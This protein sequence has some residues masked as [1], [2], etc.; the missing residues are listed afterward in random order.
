M[1]ITRQAI[2]KLRSDRSRQAHNALIR[3]SF[4]NAVKAMR[5]KPTAKALAS[6]FT[7]LDKAAK[8]NVIHKNKASRL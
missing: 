2:K 5:K 6:A 3:E 7:Q 8:T 1:P 4:R